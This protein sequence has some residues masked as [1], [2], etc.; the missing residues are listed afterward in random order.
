[1]ALTE[2]SNERS[3][4]ERLREALSFR[5]P[6]R[7]PLDLSG[8]TVSAIGQ[9]IFERVM[10]ARGLPAGH[11]ERPIDPIQGI[12]FPDAAALDALEVDT[13]RLG[14]R[15]IMDFEERLQRDGGR[16]IIRDAYGCDWEKREG[17]DLYYN[18][19]GAPLDDEEEELSDLL[20]DFRIYDIRVFRDRLKRD[21]VGQLERVG[22]RGLILD[23]N[24]AGLTE[25]SL[26]LRGY[27]NWFMDTVEDE[28]GVARLL[29]LLLEHKLA[30]WDLLIELVEELGVK[31]RVQVCAEADDLGT[32]TSLLLAPEKLRRLLF[33]RLA[34]LSGFLK[35]RLPG[36]RFFFHSDGAILPI[37][38]DMIEAGV[39]IL[40]PIQTRAAG[41]DAAVIKERFGKDLVLWGGGI[42][43]QE[44]LN[45]AS[46]EDVVA[47]VRRNLEILAPGGGYVFSTVHNIQDDVPVENFLALWETV[48][49]WPDHP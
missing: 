42:D 21:L 19:S 16:L 37:I 15:R 6:D 34:E 33:P 25:V 17:K 43:T 24:C 38:P 1:M 10:A 41:M 11:E 32:Q 4:A 7:P 28:A 20:A 12:V 27:E 31:E 48:S 22:E 3:G 29:D 2:E 45:R 44:V 5:E 30:Y 26:R 8:T 36:A 39:E 18:Q 46:P 13:C 47:E 14:A 49:R 23:R 35:K 9:G 40:N